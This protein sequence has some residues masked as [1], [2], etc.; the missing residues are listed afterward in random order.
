M[1]RLFF[2]IFF[3]FITFV[4]NAQVEH[5]R[6]GDI[7]TTVTKQRMM[8]DNNGDLLHQ[9]ANEFS[10]EVGDMLKV[11]YPAEVRDAEVTF[12]VDRKTNMLVLKYTANIVRST[13]E[14]AEYHFD[15]RGSMS[16][17]L[18]RN[19]A[20]NDSKSRAHEQFVDFKIPVQHWTTTTKVCERKEKGQ[21]R[22]YFAITEYLMSWPKE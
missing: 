20:I 18:D 12:S 9:V 21:P 2:S 15:H 10:K 5:Y 13:R 14:G 7:I 19:S 22:Y 3:I 1:K 8:P 16:S 4:V 17:A 6:Y 11:H